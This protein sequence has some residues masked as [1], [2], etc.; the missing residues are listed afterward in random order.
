MKLSY[1]FIENMYIYSVFNDKP[2]QLKALMTI[3]F[4][5]YSLSFRARHVQSLG[6][7]EIKI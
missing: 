7:V 6:F 2:W 4:W 1:M 3:I 5:C